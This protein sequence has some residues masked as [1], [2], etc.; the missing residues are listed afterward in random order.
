[1]MVIMMKRRTYFYDVHTE[2][3]YLSLPDVS[4][5]E[6][7]YSTNGE[8]KKEMILYINYCYWNAPENNS[9]FSLTFLCTK[10]SLGC[11]SGTSGKEDFLRK[12]P[13]KKHGAQVGG[14]Y[15]TYVH[16]WKANKYTTDS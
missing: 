1:M 4:E 6:T 15:A 8:L 3:K 7:V 16:R 10:I 11:L 14:S 9:H 13:W 5:T 2:R 12:S